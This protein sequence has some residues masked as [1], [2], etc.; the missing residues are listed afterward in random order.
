MTGLNSD[1]DSNLWTVF[2]PTDAAIKAAPAEV[3][4]P[5]MADM[6]LLKDIL[7]FHTI[8]EERLRKAK[9]RCNDKILM[10]NGKKSRTVCRYGKKFQRGRGNERKLKAMPEIVIKNIPTCNGLV[11]AIDNLMLP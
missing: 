9:L 2:A 11:H 5:A 6:E 1:L 8:P 3:L 4:V 7:L 10:G